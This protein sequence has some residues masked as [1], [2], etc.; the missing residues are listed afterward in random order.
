MRLTLT[1]ADNKRHARRGACYT[2][3]A[4]S[5]ETCCGTA[6][7][8]HVH[9]NEPY[10]CAAGFFGGVEVNAVQHGKRFF[11]IKPITRA[12]PN[13]KGSGYK[14]APRVD[15]RSRDNWRLRGATDEGG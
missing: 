13:R 4:F 9:V 8:G 5:W 10:D 1:V 2:R 12:A 11:G 14:H 15:N 7:N 6:I 3:L